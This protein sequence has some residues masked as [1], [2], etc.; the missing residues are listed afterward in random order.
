MT[1]ILLNKLNDSGLLNGLNN[2]G[3]I[4]QTEWQQF[5]NSGCLAAV[6][7]NKL[8]GSCFTKKAV[9]QLFW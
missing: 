1:M 7:L 2:S 4:K 3:F 5:Y 9:R 6:L 8:Y